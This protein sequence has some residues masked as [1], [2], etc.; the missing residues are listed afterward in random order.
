MSG[1]GVLATLL[2]AAMLLVPLILYGMAHGLGSYWL[3]P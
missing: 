2:L 3:G 1:P